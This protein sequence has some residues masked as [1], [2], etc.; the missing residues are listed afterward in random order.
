[1]SKERPAEAGELRNRLLHFT[2]AVWAHA[3]PGDPSTHTNTHHS[4]CGEGLANAK[5]EGAAPH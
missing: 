1:M 5:V 3:K 4:V 2:A